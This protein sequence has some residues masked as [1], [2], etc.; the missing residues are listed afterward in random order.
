MRTVISR[1][2]GVTSKIMAEIAVIERTKVVTKPLKN[3][4]LISGNVTV[5]NTFA[6][7]AP[8]SG[9]FF[10]GTVYLP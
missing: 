10:D 3:D 8:K 5:V 1:Y 4:S 6:L 7:S 2:F 9:R